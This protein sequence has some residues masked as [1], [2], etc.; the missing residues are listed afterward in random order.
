[1]KRE[2]MKQYYLERIESKLESKKFEDEC[3]R[4]AQAN[5]EEARSYMKE[6]S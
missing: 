3:T 1:M 5:E 4:E 6:V 2:S